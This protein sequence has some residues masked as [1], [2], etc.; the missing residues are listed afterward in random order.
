MEEEL[1]EFILS[2]QEYRNLYSNWIC[3]HSQSDSN[4]ISDECHM[5]ETYQL[6][7]D[8]DYL[9]MNDDGCYVF[10]IRDPK[11]FIMARI[12]YDF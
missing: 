4:P 5:W 10:K 12:K 7:T 8:D 2:I 6:Y 3:N 1:T 11:K 9:Q